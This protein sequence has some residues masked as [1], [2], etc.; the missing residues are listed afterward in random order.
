MDPLEVLTSA[1]KAYGPKA[2]AVAAFVDKKR[3]TL[4]SLQPGPQHSIS[5]EN[6]HA[7]FK[8]AFQP[9][10]KDAY[11]YETGLGSSGSGSSSESSDSPGSSGT[12]GG[13]ACGKKR[14]YG[15]FQGE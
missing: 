8:E 12:S 14:R 2:Y 7:I 3:W 5:L 11:K 4:E 9:K 1:V 13:I 6:I 10:N 15:T